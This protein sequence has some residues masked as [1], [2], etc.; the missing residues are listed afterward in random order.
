MAVAAGLG[1]VDDRR[2]SDEMI[3]AWIVLCIGVA[4]VY[5]LGRIRKALERG[6][7]EQ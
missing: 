5:E 6:K 1:L 3:T 7:G 2:G 4:V